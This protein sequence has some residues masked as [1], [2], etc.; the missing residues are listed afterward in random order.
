MLNGYVVEQICKVGRTSV[1]NSIHLLEM[2][3]GSANK[4]S[5]HPLLLGILSVE[6]KRGTIL[7]S[8]GVAKV[9]H[10]LGSYV[11]E[12]NPSYRRHSIKTSLDF[13]NVQDYL[14]IFL[15][16]MQRIV[17][18][19]LRE[20]V[21]KDNEQLNLLERVLRLFRFR[22]RTHVAFDSCEGDRCGG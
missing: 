11:M 4:Q 22:P 15:L 13:P 18:H 10:L 21:Q 7:L 6:V 8:P 14:L 17:R 9:F 3:D 12:C 16:R 5:A 1:V 20:R 2:R 19:V